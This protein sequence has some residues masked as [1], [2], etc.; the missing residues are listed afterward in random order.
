M[1]RSQA[2]T[3]TVLSVGKNASGDRLVQAA[4]KLADGIRTAA[5]AIPSTKIPASVDVR[6][7]GESLVFV[8]ANAP[9]AYPIETGARHP[10]FG[11]TGRA[12]DIRLREGVEFTVRKSAGRQRVFTG[13]GKT[14]K[15]L[16]GVWRET[17]QVLFMEQGTAAA[18]DD[19]ADVYGKTV[20]D[21]LHAVG[22]E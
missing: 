10:V 19:A 4:D 6:P 12:D 13:K 16:K 9:N 1:T 20:D 8:V 17:K 2:S 21:W 15:E 11:M 7:A 22:W 5:R 18:I 14:R 3:A